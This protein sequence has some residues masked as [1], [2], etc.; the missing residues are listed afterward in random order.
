MWGFHFAIHKKIIL[1]LSFLLFF[2]QFVS[3]GLLIKSDTVCT[4]SFNDQ[5]IIRPI[6]LTGDGSLYIDTAVGVEDEFFV[7]Y[8]DRD[9]NCLKV[10]FVQDDNIVIDIVDSDAVGLYSSIKV[11]SNNNLHVSY[12]DS[13]NDDLKYAFWD[14][15]KWSVEIVDSSGDVGLYTCIDVDSLN[16]PHISYY[17]ASN[18]DLKYCYW[19]GEGWFFE[20]VAYEQDVGLATS[21][22]LDSN[23]VAHV[24]FTDDA[25]NFLYYAEKVGLNWMITLVDDDCI[26]FG[27]TSIDVDSDNFAHISYFDVGTSVEDWNLKHAYYDGNFWFDEIVDPD[28]RY[29]WNDWGVSIVVDD[30]DRVHIGY[31]CW[32]KWDLKYAYKTSDRWSIETVESDGDSGVYASIILNSKNYPLI[33][34]MSRSS[35]ELKYAEKIQ[36][37]PDQPGIPVGPNKGRPGEIYKFEATGYDF[38]GDK[39]KYG[40]DWGDGSVIEF[41]DFYKSGET[42]QAVHSWDEKGVYNVKVKVVDINGYESD[43]S[44]PLKFTISKIRNYNVL[45]VLE[46]FLGLFTNRMLAG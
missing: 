17:D 26:V 45:M 34:Y 42:I 31:Y 32:Y 15:Y 6:E 9:L 8:Y 4:E 44:E 46:K 43:W 38:D 12:Y 1:L 30:F 11:D 41:T 3:G 25:D 10:A 5:W 18:G 2:S 29:F 19:N 23:N 7:S 16:H 14:G 40:W 27:S 22:V 20:I 35:L 37:S 28:L 24:S 36:Y 21:L 39:V 33:F 13:F